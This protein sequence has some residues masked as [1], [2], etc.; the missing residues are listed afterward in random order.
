MLL[1]VETAIRIEDYPERI[2]T[3]DFP[4]REAWVVCCDCSG[5]HNYSID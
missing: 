1:L 2:F 4:Y 5:S 3:G